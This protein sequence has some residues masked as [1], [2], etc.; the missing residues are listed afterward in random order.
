MWTTPGG[1]KPQPPA[2]IQAQPENIPLS[3]TFTLNEGY[4]SFQIL[5]YLFGLLI[6]VRNLCVDSQQVFSVSKRGEVRSKKRRPSAELLE[7]FPTFNR[8]QSTVEF[9]PI[10]PK[11]LSEADTVGNGA[12]YYKVSL[13]RREILTPQFEDPKIREWNGVQNGE[14]PSKESLPAFIGLENLRGE[15][16]ATD[17]LGGGLPPIGTLFAICDNLHLSPASAEK[18]GRNPHLGSPRSIPFYQ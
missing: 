13:V 9:K 3:L 17:E 5:L 18:Y 7:S 16:D 12:Y 14:S 6:S 15:S 8:T 1:T 2:A 11:R 10:Y 4:V